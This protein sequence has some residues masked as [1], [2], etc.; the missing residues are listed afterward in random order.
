M[1][2]HY[3]IARDPRI[4]STSSELHTDDDYSKIALLTLTILAIKAAGWQT[5][6]RIVLLAIVSVIFFWRD[7]PV[8]L[9]EQKYIS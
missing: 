5:F 3:V 8:I 1:T 6:P 7:F 9:N 2:V 4:V